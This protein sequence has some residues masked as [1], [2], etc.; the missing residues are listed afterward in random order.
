MNLLDPRFKYVPAAAT[1]VA[2][3]WQRFGFDSR[4][5]EERRIRVRQRLFEADQAVAGGKVD[6]G[7][8]VVEA[9]LAHQPRSIGLYRLRRQG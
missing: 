7:D 3:T 1:D 8:H 9:E 4:R 6:Q 5:N 2:S